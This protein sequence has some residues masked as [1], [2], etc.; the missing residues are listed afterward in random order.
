[1]DGIG[2]GGDC[3]QRI[4][5]GEAAIVVAVPIDANFFAAGLD[6][7]AD[8]KL[9]EVVRALGRGVADRVAE[10]DGVRAVL[11]GSGV[12]T[13]DGVGVGANRV[14]RNVHAREIVRDGEFYGVFGGAEEMVDG[15]IFH[16]AANR[17]GAE[18]GGGFDGDSGALRNFND[19]ANVVFVSA[20][21]AVGFDAHAIGGDFA[22]EGFRVFA[23]PRAGAG[24]ADVCGIEAE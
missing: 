24:E 12:E 7:F 18:E 20:G 11:Y 6:D 10:D 19:R 9:N 16:D 15:P 13:F 17:A 2:A 5:D 22:S 21:G 23:G 14:F 1:M 3:P 8:D 4:G